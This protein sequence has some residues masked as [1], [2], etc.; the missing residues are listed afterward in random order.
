LTIYKQMEYK[1]SIILMLLNILSIFIK[2]ADVLNGYEF[3]ADLY[4]D[5]NDLDKQ[6]LG[7]PRFY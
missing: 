7:F 4:I 1:Y 5:N 2:S 6:Y 3:R